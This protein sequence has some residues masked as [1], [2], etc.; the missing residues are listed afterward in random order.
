MRFIETHKAKHP[1]SDRD[2]WK[3]WVLSSFSV[4]EGWQ[5]SRSL[6]RLAGKL[7]ME[8]CANARLAF[9]PNAPAVVAYDRLHS[10]QAETSSVLLG[11]VIRSKK[12]LALLGRESRA[13]I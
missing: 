13:S 12:P 10:R 8:S 11:G 4:R 7:D 5:I 2:S 3:S 6:G 1:A 9:D